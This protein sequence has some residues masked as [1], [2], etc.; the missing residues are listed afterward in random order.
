MTIICKY[1]YSIQT[2]INR[3]EWFCR[4]NTEKLFIWIY[5]IFLWKKYIGRGRGRGGKREWEG[6]RGDSLLTVS[7]IIFFNENRNAE[8]ISSFNSIQLINV[9]SIRLPNSSSNFFYRH[10]CL[11]HSLTS[12]WHSLLLHST[13]S[14][15]MNKERMW[16]DSVSWKRCF[17]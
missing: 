13:H 10:T 1:K 6:G 11:N 14:I 9:L 4:L 12:H 16:E 15:R 7:I 5:P 8:M 17:N 2:I 3:L